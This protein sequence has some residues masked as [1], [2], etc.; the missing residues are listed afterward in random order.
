M[1]G[2]VDTHTHIFNEAANNPEIGN[3][4]NAQQV[5]LQNGITTIGNLYT[6][7]EFL[8]EMRA[9]EGSG[10]LRVRTSLYLSYTTN[11]GDV[12]GDWYREFLPTREPGEMLRIAG[13]KVFTDGGS[14]KFPAVSFDHPEWGEGDLFFTQDEMNTIVSDI[15]KAGYQVAIHAIGDRAV[16]Q[17]L[18]AIEFAL[19]GQ[20]NTLRHRIEHNTIVRPDLFPRYQEVGA[21]A[22]VIGNIWSC[23]M[24]LDPSESRAWYFPYRGMLDASPDAHIAWH[25][26]YPWS[27]Q[28]PLFHLYSLVTP[29]E[30]AGDGTE[31]ADPSGISKTM[32]VDEALPMMT[33]EGAYIMFRDE[34]VGSLE[35]GKYA[36]LIILSGNPTTDL[37]AVRNIEVWMT[38][39]GGHVEWCAPNHEELCPG[40]VV[41]DGSPISDPVRIRIQLTTTSDWATLSLISGGTLINPQVVSASAEATNQGAN[42]N[43][44]FINQTIARANSGARV[45]LVV[46]AYLSDA[47]TNGQLEFV[48]ESGAIGDTTV[49]LLNYVQDSPVEVSTIVLNE[50]SKVF[51][52]PI[53]QFIAP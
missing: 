26:D 11:C 34:E 41:T 42:D 33:I 22:S 39:V 6:T 32:T 40:S 10:Q 49:K 31:C 47:Q 29:Y 35:P 51:N 30:I 7:R 25:T 14:C 38:M 16:E 5:V 9:I 48:I 36:D 28:N 52:V 17:A 8:A 45:E 46:D 24:T 20:P 13:V 2:F 18:N 53:E 50:M 23:N 37:N 4:K 44:F 3:I 43:R 15:N 1:P 19:D 12:L 21:V 27:S